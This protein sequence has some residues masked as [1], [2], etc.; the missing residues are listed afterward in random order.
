MGFMGFQARSDY[1]WRVGEW[2]TL[3]A[4][5][6]DPRAR[7]SDDTEGDRAEVDSVDYTESRDDPAIDGLLESVRS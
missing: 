4:I 7:R 1:A 2:R 3:N 5:E 6:V